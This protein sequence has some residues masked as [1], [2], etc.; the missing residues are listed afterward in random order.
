MPPAP[1]EIITGGGKLSA[2]RRPWERALIPL[3][4]QTAPALNAL[5]CDIQA[6]AHSRISRLQLA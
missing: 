6:T 3:F 4:S 5:A 1:D 2:E